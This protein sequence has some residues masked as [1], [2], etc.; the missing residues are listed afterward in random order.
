MIYF[1]DKELD[2]LLLEDIY[3]GDLTT[4]ALGIENIPAKILFKRK[5]AGIVAGVSVAEKLLK[6]L[7]IQPHLYVKEGEWVESGTLLI[8]A[9]G[10][11]EQLHQPWKVVQ[12]VLE[13]SCGVA[14]YTA[15]MIANA[16]A[17]N[18]SA[19]VGCT[20]KSISNTRKLA[21]NAVLAAG[22]HIH[23]QGVSETLLVFTN[24]RNL[25]S[26]PNDWTK[27]VDRLRQEAPENKITLEADNCAQF[28]QMYVAEPDIIQLDKWSLDDVKKALALLQSKQ[29]DILL[30]VVGGV[31]KDNVS[32]Y[33]KLGIR[34]FTTSAPYY[35]PPEDIK[36]VIE[37]R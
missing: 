9:E 1:S 35:A 13:W 25:L 30:S 36:V 15:E 23:R 2:D 34:L 21:T 6:K 5:N 3:R 24:H 16:K 17:V 8:S 14:Q 10:I 4:H 26:D 29:K 37:K 7:D 32:D 28:E 11:S 18:P 22:G 19:V 27:I 33:A 12:L 31:N 20:R